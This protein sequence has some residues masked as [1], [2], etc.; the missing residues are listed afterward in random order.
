MTALFSFALSPNHKWGDLVPKPK[1]HL[2]MLP[3]HHTVHTADSRRTELE[4]WE[5]DPKE[6]GEM[7]RVEIAEVFRAG[8]SRV[9]KP[10]WGAQR[11]MREVWQ[12]RAQV[13]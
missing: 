11:C 8:T 2:P 1:C 9:G 3:K 5:R 4:G 6:L 13:G 10:A 12:D 7:Q